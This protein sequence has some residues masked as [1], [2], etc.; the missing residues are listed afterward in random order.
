MCSGS[1][2]LGEIV[3]SS[4]SSP[5]WLGGISFCT[6]QPILSRNTVALKCSILNLW[7]SHSLGQWCRRDDCPER[8]FSKPN[9]QSLGKMFQI[10]ILS[11]ARGCHIAVGDKEALY[12]PAEE[13]WFGCWQ[14]HCDKYPCPGTPTHEHE[15][16][17]PNKWKQCGEVSTI[18][19]C[20]KQKSE[21]IV[22]KDAVMLLWLGQVGVSVERIGKHRHF[23]RESP[24]TTEI[25]YD[26]CGD[27]AF[28][29]F[30]A[31]NGT[32]VTSTASSCH[33]D[34]VALV[35]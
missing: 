6:S 5:R 9:S 4:N 31:H 28:K 24:A 22:N 16:A 20:G 23:S 14:C 21:Q 17:D 18:Y 26:R 27:E 32:S 2:W 10:Y 35:C 8:Y 13:K 3:D 19:A 29:N 12:Y 30:K 1:E 15:F 34:N 11:L 33:T 25:H 7:L